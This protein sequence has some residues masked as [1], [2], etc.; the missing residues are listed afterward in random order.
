MK[1]NDIQLPTQLLLCSLILE[2]QN[3]L[4]TIEKLTL[5][6]HDHEVKK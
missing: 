4:N 5:F 1:E 6:L 2:T 3:L